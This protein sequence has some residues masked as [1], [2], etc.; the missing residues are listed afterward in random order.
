[1][2]RSCRLCGRLIEFTGRAQK[3]CT[4]CAL[5]VKRAKQ[6]EYY[7]VKHGGNVRIYEKK[8]GR[9]SG[10]EYEN[11]PEKLDAIR[12]KYRNGVTVAMIADMVDR[13]M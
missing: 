8:Q 6:R 4:A 3:Y 13:L 7:A 12:E 10:L 5:K 2:E 1:M 9:F 11:P